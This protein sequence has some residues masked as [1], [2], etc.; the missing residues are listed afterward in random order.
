MQNPLMNDAGSS[1]GQTSV[2]NGWSGCNQRVSGTR[3]KVEDVKIKEL[4]EEIVL[5]GE[6]YIAHV[7]DQF[8]KQ[9]VGSFLTS[10]TTCQSDPTLS[11]AF[12][13]HLR[14]SIK[15]HSELSYLATTKQDEKS[16]A[17]F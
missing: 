5:N 8:N 3:E 2:G 4:K 9:A 15:D 7:R 11:H 10:A 14:E 13:T 17:T 1:F 6:S 12:V 16:C